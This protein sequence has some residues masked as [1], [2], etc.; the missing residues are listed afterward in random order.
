MQL[1][2]QHRIVVDGVF[3]PMGEHILDARRV[4]DRVLILADY[5]SVPKDRQAHNL[6]AMDLNHKILWTAEHPTTGTND[7]YVRILSEEPLRVSSF[8]GYSCEIDIETG[9]LLSAL[10]TK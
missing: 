10:F 5:R 1:P 7:A 3:W 8:A 9:K 4:G 2:I 6:R